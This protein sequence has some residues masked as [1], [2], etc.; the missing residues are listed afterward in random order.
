MD[1]RGLGEDEPRLEG[2]KTFCSG[3]GG[4][5]GA[6]VLARDRVRAERD[7]ACL[8]EV[9]IAG[10]SQKAGVAMPALSQPPA[11]VWATHPALIGGRQAT[12]S[13][14]QKLQTG[15]LL[16]SILRRLAFV[17]WRCRY[18]RWACSTAGRATTG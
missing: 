16:A 8:I 7:V 9:A 15:C 18:G 13:I 2:V 14:V 1:P 4:L 11:V 6:L 17:H 3:A 12:V 5:H 10:E